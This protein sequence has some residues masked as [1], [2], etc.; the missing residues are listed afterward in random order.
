MPNSARAMVEG[1]LGPPLTK[2]IWTGN[3]DKVFPVAFQHYE[4][5]ALF[6]AVFYMFRFG[7]R[8]GAGKFLDTFAK[9][10][11]T[12]AQRRRSATV[13]RVAGVLS[14]SRGIVGFNGGH[15]T[16]IL[17]D[18]LLCYCLENVRHNTGRDQQIQRTGSTHYMASWI[19]LPGS[20]AHLRGVPEMIVALLADQDGQYVEVTPEATRTWFP[21]GRGYEGNVLLRSFS[22]GITRHG[23]VV[24][25]RT[26][27]RFDEANQRVG[28]DQLVTIRLAAMLGSAPLS[29]PGKTASQISNQRPVAEQAAR[30]FSDD[31]RRF[32]R[33]FSEVM[34]RHALVDMLE[35]CLAVGMVT[36]FSSV[37]EMMLVWSSEG[38]VPPRSQQKPSAVLVDCSTGVDRR[39]RDCSEQCADDFIRRVERLPEVLTALRLLDYHARRNKKVQAIASTPYA[40]DWLD[41]LGDL[42]YERHD[43]SRLVHYSIEQQVGDLAD[44]LESEYP[45]A[46]GILNGG[47]VEPNPV[48]RFARGIKT[49]VGYN[50]TRTNLLGFVDSSFLTDRQNGIAAK[51]KTTRGGVRRDIRSI[52]FTD[53]VIEYLV[54]LHLLRGGSKSGIRKLSFDE[55]LNTLRTRYGFHIDV[56]PP[57]MSI[58]N[59]LLQRNRTLFERRLRDL[60]LLDGVN[61]S[62]SMKRLCPRFQPLSGR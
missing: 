34:P 60:G 41:L 46:A 23:G 56:A 2:E 8:R 15:G 55:F 62:E 38:R 33:A 45:E 7:E 22:Q 11:G 27:D 19:D 53:P 1:V 51:R 52:V 57:G 40:T 6:P 30:D 42:L 61:D 9:R 47:E 26:S 12:L 29:V 43:E 54:H 32:L 10:E 36:V 3:Y 16:A 28:L 59:E 5:S 37:V 35:S 18:L 21:V 49:L 31:L 4:L 24:G 17:G 44:Q 14:E 48:W 20:A 13:E 39:L 50:F 25:N 58:S